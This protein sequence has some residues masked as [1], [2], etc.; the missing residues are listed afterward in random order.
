[1]NESENKQLA[2]NASIDRERMRYVNA[3]FNGT[4][5]T[6]RKR[7]YQEFGYPQDLCFDDFYRA[8]RRNAIAG[9]AVA[10]MVDGCWEDYPDV[11]EGDQT[12]DATQQTPWDKRVNK[13]LKRCWKQIKG[14]D[15]RNLVGRYSA[16]LIQV[17][18]S[19]SW[20]EPVDKA[21]VGRLQ[22][23]ALVRLIPVWEAQLDP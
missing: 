9:A 8:Y 11:Y 14:A 1:M 22:E 7:L 10:R 4:S 3:L 2:T 21:M 15:K 6:K 5:N 12:K 17:K 19:K 13:L 23:R 16:L 18:D 20:W